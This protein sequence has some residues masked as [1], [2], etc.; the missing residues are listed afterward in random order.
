MRK[1]ALE[2]S[3]DLI[4]LAGVEFEEITRRCLDWKEYGEN[5]KR[6]NVQEMLQMVFLRLS[7]HNRALQ[8]LL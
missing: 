1:V 7:E 3:H 6:N 5:Q 4:R 2:K 8:R